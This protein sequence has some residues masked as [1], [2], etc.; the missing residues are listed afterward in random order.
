LSGSSSTA[1]S[2]YNRSPDLGR[3]RASDRSDRTGPTLA[4]GSRPSHAALD[5][6]CRPLLSGMSVWGASL[7][8]NRLGDAAD[9]RRVCHCELTLTPPLEA[10]PACRWPR[11]G[12]GHQRST[13]PPAV[14]PGRTTCPFSR[15]LGG[16][17][18]PTA[19][20][21]LRRRGL[22]TAVPAR[23]EGATTLTTAF[24]QLS[25]SAFPCAAGHWRPRPR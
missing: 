22:R 9:S 13:A 21:K 17:T 24:C 14:H 25:S 5:H 8:R 4:S 6:L 11:T 19:P 23:R 2:A 20:T 15:N 1:G 12:R 10:R 7:C 3:D 18:W 16:R